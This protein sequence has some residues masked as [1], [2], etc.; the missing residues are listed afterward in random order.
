MRTYASYLIVLYFFL[1]TSSV[2]ADVFN[3]QKSCF[4]KEFKESET[5]FSYKPFKRNGCALSLICKKDIVNLLFAELKCRNGESF[6]Y[7]G[8][9]AVVKGE[10]LNSMKYEAGDLFFTKL[11]FRNNAFYS[12][13]LM[14]AVLSKNSSVEHE[15]LIAEYKGEMV[16]FDEASGTLVHVKPAPCKKDSLKIRDVCFKNE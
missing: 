5:E 13:L 7:L 10:Y 4:E 2:W 16:Y 12:G 14:K 8:N 9:S 1:V 11:M 15:Q 3:F 6:Y